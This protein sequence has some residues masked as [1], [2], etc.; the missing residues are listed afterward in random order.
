MHCNKIAV[1]DAGQVAEFGSPAELLARSESIFASLA[2]RS[3]EKLLSK[4]A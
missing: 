3:E 1:M 2:K 4:Y